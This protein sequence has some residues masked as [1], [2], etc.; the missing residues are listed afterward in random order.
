MR[1]VGTAGHVDH[2]KSSLVIS[3]TGHN[4]DRW[5]EERERGM[6]LDLGF[7]PL[8]FADGVEAGIIDVPGHERFIHNMLAG[9]AGIDVLLLVVDALEGPRA[10]T[11]E[12][13]QILGFLNVA[14]SIVALTKVDLADDEVIERASDGVR[15]AIVG[16]VAD[17]APIISVSNATGAGIDALK[18]AIHDALASLPPRRVDAP[19]FLPVDRVFALPGHGTIVTG[20]LM[21]GTIHAGE[22]LTLQP[23]GTPARVRSLQIF[24]RKTE[25]ASAGVRLAINVPGIDASTARRGDV[26]AA[27]REFEPTSELAIEFSPLEEALPLLRRRTPVRVHVGS[28]EIEGRL[29]FDER[30]ASSKPARALVELTRPTVTYPGARLIVRR[31]SPKDLLGGGIVVKSGDVVGRAKLGISAPATDLVAS[32]DDE[33]CFAAIASSGLSPVALRKVASAANVLEPAA[34]TAVDRLVEDGRIIALAKPVEYIGRDVYEAS[35]E[36]SASALRE[37]HASASWRLGCSTS[38][39]AAALGVDDSLAARLLSAWHE[40]GR[41]AVRARFWRLPDFTPSLTREQRTFFDESFRIDAA[42]PLVPA[43][44]SNAMRHAEERRVAG[45]HEAFESLVAAGQLVRIGD[46][47]YRR[48]Q[49]DRARATVEN[50]LANGVSATASQLRIALEV[51]RKYALPLLEHF[52]SIGVTV[53]D[54]DHRRLRINA[55][56]ARAIVQ[57]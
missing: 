30:P 4:P 43:S 22:T 16:T 46:D 28:A 52:D 21:Q 48:N 25:S 18:S 3:L 40:D 19:A 56:N 37:R 20:T 57:T 26:L 36:R 14:K 38:E 55:G 2:G 10:Q 9:A 12:H 8:K 27:T 29:V 32:S 49:F 13:L 45:A 1:I 47:V 6:T 35:F 53:R 7:A 5:V 54:G 39:I 31:L 42:A 24:G 15:D 23:S 17:G 44:Y 34:R 41:V 11:R 33:T 50:A 51:S